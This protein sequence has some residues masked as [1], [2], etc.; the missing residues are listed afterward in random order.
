VTELISLPGIVAKA[1]N[2]TCV[3][4]L[5]DGMDCGAVLQEFS[6]DSEVV[7]DISG[8]PVELPNDQDLDVFLFSA[9]G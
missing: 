3:D 4:W 1:T 9:K 6:L 7:F 8:K 2:R 5:G